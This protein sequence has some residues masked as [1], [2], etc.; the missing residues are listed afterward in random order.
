MRPDPRHLIGAG[1]LFV[2]QLPGTWWPQR[3][4]LGDVGVCRALG[5]WPKDRLCS[6]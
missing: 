3:G 5:M 6:L 2:T 1:S 4:H